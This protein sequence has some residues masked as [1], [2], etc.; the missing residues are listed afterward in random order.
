MA[1]LE[2]SELMVAIRRGAAWSVTADPR[3]AAAG[4]DGLTDRL[5]LLDE[6]R[7]DASAR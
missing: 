2:S 3:E 7:P 4:A 6:R 5:A 1:P